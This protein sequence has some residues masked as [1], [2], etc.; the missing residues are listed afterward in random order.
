MTI[1]ERV[2]ER[3]QQLG[4]T[5]KELSQRTGIQQSTISEWKKNHTNPSSDKILSLCHILKVSPEW[6]LS[7]VEPAA[8]RFRS[9]DYYV[10]D[11]DT[12]TGYLVEVYNGMDPAARN[13]LIGYAVALSEMVKGATPSNPPSGKKAPC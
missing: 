5:Q 10:I 7:G 11:K 13:R 9:M 4:M 8:S 1:S 2:F 3:L 6:L 12:E